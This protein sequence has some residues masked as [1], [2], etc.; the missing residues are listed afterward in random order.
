MDTAI[1]QPVGYFTDTELVIFK[2][3]LDPFDLFFDIKM[4]NRFRLKK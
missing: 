3:F 4:L 2:Q 1:T